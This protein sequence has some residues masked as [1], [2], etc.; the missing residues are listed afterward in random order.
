MSGGRNAST[1]YAKITVRFSSG[2]ETFDRRCF[3]LT[4]VGLIAIAIIADALRLHLSGIG[5]AGKG[6][7]ALAS[8]TSSGGHRAIVV[9]NGEGAQ[10]S[11]TTDRAAPSQVAVRRED[12][13]KDASRDRQPV[14]PPLLQPAPV[15]A[16][17]TP[18]LTAALEP[19]GRPI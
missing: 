1:L 2:Y 8:G 15:A 9:D 14:S 6:N 18:A 7:R 10:I 11:G 13:V 16:S 12:A 3:Y 4:A 5:S 17:D 19:S